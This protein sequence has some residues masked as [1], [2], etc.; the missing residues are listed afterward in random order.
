MMELG[1]VLGRDFAAWRSAVRRWLQRARGSTRGVLCLLL[2][3]AVPCPL[4]AAVV[5]VRRGESAEQAV[6]RY[7]GIRLEGLVSQGTLGKVYKGGASRGAVPRA[8]L[9]ARCCYGCVAAL[10][11]G[12]PLPRRAAA[13]LPQHLT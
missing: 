3:S 4:F 1:T 11:K 10:A 6:A 7:K 12:L 2:A 13:A 8:A 9:P 5:S